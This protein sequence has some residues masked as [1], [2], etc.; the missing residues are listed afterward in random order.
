MSDMTNHSGE[1]KKKPKREYG[2]G[3][4]RPPRHSQW[5]PGRSGNPDGRRRRKE[6]LGGDLLDKILAEKIRGRENGKPVSVTRRRACAR[7]V[8]DRGITGDPLCENI[9][10]KIEGPALAA[11][12]GCLHWI[13]AATEEEIPARQREVLAKYK[14]RAARRPAGD[15]PG[16][17]R[18]RPRDDAPFS[19]LVK[20]DLNMTVKIEVNGRVR[21]I[22]RRELW[23]R[24]LVNGVMKGDP[25][26]IR[27]FMKIA[28]PTEPPQDGD[29]FFC[30]I[31]G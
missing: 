28:K 27:S 20:R 3:Y 25:R 11:R 5:P 13:D 8:V 12:L 23:L 9:L 18:G 22:S 1:A 17:G 16:Y 6:E 15:Q 24:R 30:L 4:C 21:K 7:S 2:T 19:E 26:C 31:G 29:S 14:R 10:I